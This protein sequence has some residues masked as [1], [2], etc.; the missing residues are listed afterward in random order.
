MHT[1]SCD[2]KLNF[3]SVTGSR[4]EAHMRLVARLAIVL[5]QGLWVRQTTIRLPP[6]GGD[7][8][9]LVGDDA[10]QPMRITVVGD[11]TAAGCGVDT[12]DDGFAGNL[13]R[14]LAQRSARS[15]RW[16]VHGIPGA[17]I[18]DVRRHC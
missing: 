18:G 11:S 3:T 12:H 15:V 10:E 16:H 1:E 4:P 5:G 2:L 13:A 9:G 17:T 8:T 14:E 7:R 6:A